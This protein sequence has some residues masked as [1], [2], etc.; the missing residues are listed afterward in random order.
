[1]ADLL[2]YPFGVGAEI[3]TLAA[4]AVSVESQVVLHVAVWS[5]EAV[6]LRIWGSTFLFDTHSG[7]H[8]KLIHF[9]NISLA[10]EWISM[11]CAIP[12]NFTLIFEGLPKS[13][14]QFDLIEIGFGEGCF[15]F[16]NILRNE[17]DV[18][19]VESNFNY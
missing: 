5:D 10:P 7:H 16:K 17:S 13:C 4:S 11:K 14:I 2:K 15:E 19:Y 9:D 6:N 12:H 18:Y 3:S 8:S 1:M